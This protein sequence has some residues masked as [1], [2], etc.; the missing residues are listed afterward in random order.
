M[1]KRYFIN[2]HDSIIGKEILKELTKEEAEEGTHMVTYMD[3]SKTERVKGVKKVLNRLTKP[4]L[5]RK[6]MLEE[7]D[8]YIYD[9][10]FGDLDDVLFGGNVLDKATLEEQKVE[11]NK[12]IQDTYSFNIFTRS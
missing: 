9:L 10:H 4:K 5:M 12:I 7:C 6:K 11:E 2:N 1:S 3:K 8:V